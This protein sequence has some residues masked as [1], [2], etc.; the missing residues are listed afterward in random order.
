MKSH[1]KNI[2]VI[3]SIILFIIIFK[4]YDVLLIIILKLNNI[5]AIHTMKT[6]FIH[7]V[8][9][10]FTLSTIPLVFF[11]IQK[12]RLMN[13]YFYLLR[14]PLFIIM[15]LFI[16]TVFSYLLLYNPNSSQ[17]VGVKVFNLEFVLLSSIIVNTFMFYRILKHQLSKVSSS[18][19][20]PA[21]ARI[22]SRGS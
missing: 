4:Y 17:I 9:F 5:Y 2:S 10:S 19:N 3:I 11:S 15:I 14:L 21:P 1:Q 12:N 20:V 16:F 7:H 13:I 8:I 6:A 18:A 22:P